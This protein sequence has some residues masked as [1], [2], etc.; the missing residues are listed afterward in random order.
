MNKEKLS[1]E[2]INQLQQAIDEAAQADASA[3]QK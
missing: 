1:A 3:R 2:E